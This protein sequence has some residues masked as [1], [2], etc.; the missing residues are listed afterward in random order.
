MDFWK[1]MLSGEALA[2]HPHPGVLAVLPCL[3]WV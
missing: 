1:E 2:H 3:G